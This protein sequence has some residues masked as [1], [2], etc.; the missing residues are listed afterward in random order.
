[1]FAIVEEP[2]DVG[3]LVR[4]AQRPDC[5]AVATFV[6]TTRIDESEGAAVEYLE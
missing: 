3:A 2:L 6:G 4:D 5:G 1:M